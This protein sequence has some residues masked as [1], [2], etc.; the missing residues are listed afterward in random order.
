[1]TPYTKA[2]HENDFPGYQPTELG[3]LDKKNFWATRK[4]PFVDLALDIHVQE[5]L[6]YAQDH[7]DD[8]FE[9]AYSVTSDRER[10]GKEGRAWFHTFHGQGWKY[11]RVAGVENTS[12]VYDQLNN[13]ISDNLYQIHA[14]REHL[15]LTLRQKF[16]E[17]GLPLKRLKINTLEPDGFIHPH[18]DIKT[19]GLPPMQYFWMPLNHTS[20]GLKIWPYGYIPLKLG[21]VYLFNA[22]DFVHS[23]INTEKTRRFVAVGD[24]DIDNV[25]EEGWQLIR[26]SVQ[27][28]W[29]K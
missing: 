18:L 3:V 8:L 26:D 19:K 12:A 14:S 4:I 9:E 11:C 16:I 17:L 15:F 28:Q 23:V 20:P 6:R 7:F 27:S 25:T 5:D 13:K 10:A 29:Y 1:M 22:E 21:H 2:F 24:I